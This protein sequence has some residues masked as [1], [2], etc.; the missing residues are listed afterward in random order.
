MIDRQVVPRGEARVSLP[1]P[2]ARDKPRPL[3]RGTGDNLRVYG[4]ASHPVGCVLVVSIRLIR[5][6]TYITGYRDCLLV[7][8]LCTELLYMQQEHLHKQI[9]IYR[10][11]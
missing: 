6:Y 3:R 7:C 4:I 5:L 8:T 9:Y 1:T 11:G 2:D 10:S